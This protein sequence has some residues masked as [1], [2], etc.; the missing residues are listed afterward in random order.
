MKYSIKSS[1]IS[2]NALSSAYF[3]AFRIIAADL[4]IVGEKP[5]LYDF[6]KYSSLYYTLCTKSQLYIT[7]SVF[8]CTKLMNCD[9]SLLTLHIIGAIIYTNNTKEG[10]VYHDF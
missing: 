6:N 10:V 8:K 5:G 1:N 2:K 7:I 9:K 3:A 4:S